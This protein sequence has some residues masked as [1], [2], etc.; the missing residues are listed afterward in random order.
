M[1]TATGS[2]MNDGV[3]TM[4]VERTSSS[5]TANRT[6]FSR[7]LIAA[8]AEYGNF[9]GPW[10]TATF[11]TRDCSFTRCFSP[12]C[13][14]VHNPTVASEAQQTQY[15]YPQPFLLLLYHLSVQGLVSCDKSLLRG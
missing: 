8:M 6:G 5:C 9:L 10:L 3:R 11:C 12:C 14:S 2:G 4:V 1:E 13:A 15:T 7:S